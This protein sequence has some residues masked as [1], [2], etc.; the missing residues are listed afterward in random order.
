M[1]QVVMKVANNISIHIEGGYLQISG[2]VPVASAG[3]E[4]ESFIRE[5]KFQVFG[6][7][8]AQNDCPPPPSPKDLNEKDAAKYIGR[9]VS[10]LRSCRYKGKHHGR[11]PGPKYAR[12]S[13]RC[14]RYPVSELDNWLESRRLYRACCEEARPAG[15]GIENPC[16]RQLTRGEVGCPK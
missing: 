11:D 8:Q 2:Q 5:L 6:E 7:A 1:K 16:C 13:E 10:F 4:I 14:I 15:S 12:D 3:A 9:S